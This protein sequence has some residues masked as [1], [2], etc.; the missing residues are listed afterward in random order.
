MFFVF[1]D[2][3]VASRYKFFVYVNL[4]VGGGYIYYTKYMSRVPILM[5]N[6]TF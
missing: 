6:I 4:R 3:R 5:L 2:N 1:V